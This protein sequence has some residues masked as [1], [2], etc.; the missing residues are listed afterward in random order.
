V[1]RDAQG[2]DLSGATAEAATVYDQA[3]RAFNLVHGDATGLFDEACQAAAEF[4]MAYLGRAW[5][6]A[7]GNDP[8]SGKEAGRNRSAAGVERA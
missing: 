2:H 4:A 3:V 7:L 6:F 8:D 5:V 1:I